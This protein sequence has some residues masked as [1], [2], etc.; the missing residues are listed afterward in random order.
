MRGSSS[1]VGSSGAPSGGTG[2][3]TSSSS[4][5]R[6]VG[7]HAKPARL[8]QTGV[9]RDQDLQRS[10]QAVSNL[11]PNWY[12]SIMGTGI[13][14]VAAASLPWQPRGL[15]VGA[16]VVWMLAAVLL[17][18]LTAATGISWVR[19]PGSARRQVLSHRV[20]GLA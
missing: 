6:V 9:L 15:H 12:A 10:A 20:K 18:A 17:V 11:T 1:T 7:E 4:L 19:Y 8:A 13:V 16:L 5:V 2:C 3:T 14:A